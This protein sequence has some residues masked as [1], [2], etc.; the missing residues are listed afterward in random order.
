MMSQLI[1]A[2]SQ[3]NRASDEALSKREER[4]TWSSNHIE[5]FSCSCRFAPRH[6]S[7]T[8]QEVDEMVKL[9][10]FD[11]LDALIDATVPKAIRRGPMELGEYTK[12]YT[13]SEFIAKFK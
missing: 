4:I 1:R 10:G 7:G 11:T 6:N 3:C 5:T 9:T 13:E 8:K 2:A 12:G